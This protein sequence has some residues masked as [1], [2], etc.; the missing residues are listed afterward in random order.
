MALKLDDGDWCINADTLK[1][2]TINYFKDIFSLDAAPIDS[3][4]AP[5]RFPHI[6]GFVLATLDDI[7]FDEKIHN[8]PTW[9]NLG[10]NALYLLFL[11]GG[12]MTWIFSRCIDHTVK[13]GA[14]TPLRV[15]RQ[16]TSIS[17]LFFT[18]GLILYGQA[19]QQTK[20][21]FF[22]TKNLKKTTTATLHFTPSLSPPLILIKPK[23]PTKILKLNPRNHR[24]S[25]RKSS[26]LIASSY[27]VVLEHEGKSTELEVE[28]D[29]S[30]LSK[31]LEGLDV[32]HDC[33][34][35][36]CVT[37]PAKLVSGTVDQS[38]GMLSDDVVDSGFAL[39]CV[40]YPTSDCR[41]KTIDEEQLLALQLKTAN[42]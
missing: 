14:Y 39:L 13:L 8:L 38:E 12:S 6:L 23:H 11:H 7:H 21:I 17:H 10:N 40:S 2:A 3:F 19:S 15:S 5:N 9:I 27:K 30:I 36:V 34:L 1:E 22:L 28:D 33:N 37:C 31:A 20:N 25:L 35:G 42:D 4:T 18:D 16:G 26:A 32:P 41:I 29:E 24:G